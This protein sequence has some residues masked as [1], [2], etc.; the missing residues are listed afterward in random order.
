MPVPLLERAQTR[1]HMVDQLVKV[2]DRVQ[3]RELLTSLYV[4]DGPIWGRDVRDRGWPGEVRVRSSIR[5]LHHRRRDCQRGKQRKQGPRRC[6]RARQMPPA[7][8]TRLIAGRFRR[9]YGAA[10]PR[11]YAPHLSGRTA[12]SACRVG[13]KTT[14]SFESSEVLQHVSVLLAGEQHGAVPMSVIDPF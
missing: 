7:R 4:E 8:V 14:W 13:R 2:V 1:V 5:E 3:R 9:A 10:A 11:L 12:K 6:H